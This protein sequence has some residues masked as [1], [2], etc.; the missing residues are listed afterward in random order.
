MGV[1]LVVVGV[2]DVR[3]RGKFHSY[4][5]HWAS[6]YLCTFAGI[7]ALVSSETSVFILTFMSL[8]RYLYI[9]E[10]LDDRAL[11]E[12]SAKM[13]LIVIWLTSISLA[14]F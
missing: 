4:A 3:T 9:S 8:E 7:L 12:R 5:L 6:S 1:Y 10:A 11:S 13:C 14:L 2:E